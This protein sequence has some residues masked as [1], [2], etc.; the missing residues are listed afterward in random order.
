MKLTSFIK[1][2]LYVFILAIIVFIIY[3]LLFMAFHSPVELIVAVVIL[4]FVFFL[5]SLSIDYFRKRS[6]Y[7][8][9]LSHVLKLDKSYLV[10]ET[11]DVPNFY[12]GELFVQIL[13]ETNKSMCENVSMYQN[14]MNDFKEYIEMWIHEVKIPLSS[15]NLMVHN[16]PSNYD[17]K[18]VYQLKRMEDSIEQVL[19]YVR[20]ENAT[21]DYFIKKVSLD[22][23]ITEVAL[24]NKDDFLENKMDFIVENTKVSVLTDSKWMIFIL[25]QIINNS[26]KYK[27]EESSYLKI[28]ASDKIDCTILTIYDNG[29]GIPLSDLPKV[30]LKSFTGVNGRCKRKSTGMGLFIAKS[31]C[32]KLGHKITIESMEGEFTKV[33]I[34]FYKNTH[35]DVVR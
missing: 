25:N 10:L 18:V 4:H 27:K 5:L 19:Y 3:L 30:F 15:L 23:I 26:I 13:Y 7:H 28:Q 14:Q 21:K 9:I 33:S 2:R 34:T 8:Q 35:F 29:I 20:A 6:F 31:M 32:D 24:K 16:H 17:R 22:K 12:E 11:I 1:D